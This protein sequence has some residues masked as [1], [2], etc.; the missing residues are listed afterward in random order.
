M[1]NRLL[2]LIGSL[3]LVASGAWL[4]PGSLV[5][6]TQAT[7]SNI[8]S[9]TSDGHPDLSGVYDVATITPLD[10][11]AEFGNRLVLTA[12]EAAAMEEYEQ[13]RNERDLEPV[14]PNRE[15]PPVKGG[16]KLDHR[17]GGKLDHLAAGRSS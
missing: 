7:T 8:P 14:D 9:R 15:A 2:T 11:P 16:G 5:A 13:R 17:G 10:R 3:G 4:G 1:C 6:Q 12:E